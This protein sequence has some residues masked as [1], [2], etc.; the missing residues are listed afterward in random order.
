MRRGLALPEEHEL[1]WLFEAEPELSDPSYGWV[2]NRLTFKTTRQDDELTCVID[3]GYGIVE[4]DWNRSGKGVLDLVLDNVDK[5][6]VHKDER[7][8]SML[9]SF[10]PFMVCPRLRLQLKPFVYL[11]WPAEKIYDFVE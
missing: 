10:E 8:E 4:I 3:A 11:S 1:L 6:R 9:V 5:V 7:E 2:Y